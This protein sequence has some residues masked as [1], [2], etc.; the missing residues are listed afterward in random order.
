MSEQ[1]RVVFGNLYE[2]F[3]RGLGPRLTPEV[4]AAVKQAGLDFDKLPPAVPIDEANRYSRLVGRLAFPEVPEPEAMRLLGLHAIRGWTQTTLGAAA[5]AMLR[6]IGPHRTLKRL[7]R[8]FQTTN[9]FNRA[10]TTVLGETEV[11][12]TI[13]D[14][15]DM[16][17][18]WQGVLEAGLEILRLEG[19]VVLER[20]DDP[21][22]TFHITWK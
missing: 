13:N 12:V 16:P 15:Y 5:A 20:Q 19:T 9:N 21:T 8:A 3:A 17:T 11:L 6:L 4:K 1:P 22:G 2:G 14:I 7:D 18:Y 10:T